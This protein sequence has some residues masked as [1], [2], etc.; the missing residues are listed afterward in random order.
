MHLQ[1]RLERLRSWM[2]ASASGLVLIVA[3]AHGLLYVFLMPPWQH[4]DEPGN[5]EY[6]WLAANL[7][8]WPQPG[9]YDAEMR[10]QVAAS[11][12]EADFYTGAGPNL[13]ATDP[14]VDIG[15]S[16]LDDVPLYFFLASLPLR[17]FR[18]TDIT[19]QLYTARLVSLALFLVT[20]WAALG[21]SRE[22][23]GP[24]SGLR[25]Q[26]PLFLAMLP[27]LVDLMTA[28]NNDVA[29]VAFSALFLWGCVTSLQ[30]GLTLPRLLWVVLA[31]AACLLSK[32]TAMLAL[33]LLAILLGVAVYRRLRQPLLVYLV[34]IL[35][36]AA[37]ALMFSWDTA[38]PA[39]FYAR[40]ETSLPVRQASAQAPVGKYI[41]AQPAQ[42]WTGDG[43]Y[44]MLPPAL[45]PRLQGKTLTLGMWLWA[46]QP[47]DIH[48]PDLVVDGEVLSFHASVHLERAP[49]FFAFAAS[50]PQ[51]ASLS[52]LR[53]HAA[54][55]KSA[56]MLYADGLVLALGD[57]PT[58]TPPVFQDEQASAGSWNGQSFENLLRNASAEKSWPRLRPQ[59]S[60]RLPARLNVAS[61]YLWSVADL[62]GL[63]W[64][65]QEAGEQMFETFW[66]KF[67]WAHVPLIGKR[68]YGLFS[69]LSVA[70][71][72]G[73]L[74][75]GWQ[76]RKRL[77]WGVIA[78]LAVQLLGTLALTLL[79]GSHSWITRLFIPSARYAYPAI[80]P[81]AML[82]C[83]GWFFLYDRLA[84]RLKLPQSLGSLGHIAGLA[85]YALLAVLSLLRYYQW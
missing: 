47:V 18:Y 7:D 32:A 26:V 17:L 78:F 46:D 8:H 28:V 41:F 22:L 84:S 72:A 77:P 38:S 23:F 81:L 48:F 73:A 56:G 27:P 66:Q 80:L 63:G 29:A 4:Y 24:R 50:F 61:S 10:R 49:Q 14:P 16:Q 54:S 25:W 34:V 60:Q 12:V 21:L 19:F 3:L 11:M 85:L 75:A 71:L 2:S 53:V 69:V 68:F 62:P 39:L 65:Y 44:Q 64:Y 13:L 6:A 55:Q 58:A 33:P 82:L 15:L 52:W 20:I 42:A 79:R 45:L 59:V 35:A 51:Q 67:G 1:S 9:E 5:F 36:L 31:A 37:L 43:Y 74:W 30:R 83:A 40:Q 70:G 57:F 76:H